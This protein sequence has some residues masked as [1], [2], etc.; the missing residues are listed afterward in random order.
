MAS[1]DYRTEDHEEYIRSGSG[2][3]LGTK[4]I[5]GNLTV[6]DGDLT[7]NED[8]TIGGDTTFTNDITLDG[9]AT[10]TGEATFADPIAPDGGLDFSRT[11]FAPNPFKIMVISSGSITFASGIDLVSTISTVNGDTITNFDIIS[12]NVLLRSPAGVGSPNWYA[13]NA[14]AGIAYD[15]RY[16]TGDGHMYIDNADAAYSGS[17]TIRYSVIYTL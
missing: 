15:L 4:T 12:I 6:T 13:P 5:S 11:A 16:D 14:T 9:G 1:K 7:V 17:A 10:I 2:G 8:V 3:S